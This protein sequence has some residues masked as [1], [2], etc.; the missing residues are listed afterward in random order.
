MGRLVKSPAVAPIARVALE[1]MRTN[2]PKARLR[3]TE[4]RGVT[5]ATMIYDALPINDVFRKVDAD[6]ALGVMDRRGE[7]APALLFFV[8]RRE[9]LATVPIRAEAKA[10]VYAGVQPV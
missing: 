6:T 3:M 7:K 1:M 4:F 5:T 9:R 2:K 8:L 10:P